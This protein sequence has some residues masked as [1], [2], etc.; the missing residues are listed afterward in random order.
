VIDIVGNN[1]PVFFIQDAIQFPDLIHA[2]KPQPNNEIPQAATAHDTAW[3][4]FGTNPSTM[5][6]LLWALSGHGIPR[7][8]RHV[9]GFGVHTF[10]FVKDN[11]DSK[12][13]KFHF[14][15]QQGKASFTWPEAQQL[16]GK[17][18]D[19]HRQDLWDA[20]AGGN[21]PEWEVGVQIMDEDD[22][23][24][25]GFDLLDP[26][27]LV[28]VEYVPIT[29]IGKFVLNKNVINYFAETEQS[30]VGKSTAIL[31]AI[32]HANNLVVLPWP[33]CARH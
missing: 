32:K 14:T 19:F 2:V 5:H 31:K 26:T 17:N 22:V 1:I 20:I 3:D 24:R 33:C 9:D 13:V 29:P 7:S 23:L 30:M 12:L 4:F 27:K 16:A 10:R 28:P 21:Y 6:T 15:T 11:G 18:S 8:F 25:F